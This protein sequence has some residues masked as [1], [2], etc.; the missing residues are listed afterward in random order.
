MCIKNL[1]KDEIHVSTMPKQ[2]LLVDL[3][4]I[5]LKAAQLHSR[6]ELTMNW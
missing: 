4:N 1:E 6:R 2:I 5:Y 3:H